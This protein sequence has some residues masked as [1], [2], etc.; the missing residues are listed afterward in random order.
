VAAY[1]R[2]AGV[3]KFNSKFD[4]AQG[5]FM[6]AENSGYAIFQTNCA[7]C[8][9]TTAMHGAPE[10]LFTSYGCTNIGV[11]SNPDVPSPDLGLGDSVGDTDQD[12]KF[13]IPILRNIAVTAPH[14]HN[15]RFRHLMTWSY[16]LTTAAVSLWMFRAMSVTRSATWG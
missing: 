6:T 10:P 1:E 11:R 3:S 12:G 8:H 13:K 15:G 14:A 9:A 5:Q 4:V 7:S 2:S 16:L